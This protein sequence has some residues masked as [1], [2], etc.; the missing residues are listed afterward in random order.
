MQ[1]FIAE[2]N[3]V[4]NP[5]VQKKLGLKNAMSTPRIMKIIVNVGIGSRMKNTKDYSD[6]VDNVAAITGQRPIVTFAKKAISN[7]KLRENTPNG[8]MTILRRK[9]M[10]NF[11]NRLVNVALPR[12]RDF[13]GFSEK[14]FD[15]NGNYSI[16]IK[17]CTIFPEVD[18]DDLTHVHG[19]SIT[20]VTSADND[21]ASKI[22]LSA[23]SF[24]FKKAPVVEEK[25]EEMVEEAKAETPAAEDPDETKEETKEEVKEETSEEAPEEAKEEETKS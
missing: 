4:V 7:F 19:M 11:F 18:P 2:L 14:A 23:L 6:V 16:G 13:Q 25:A 22:L 17:D 10:L 21:E 24:P 20:I 1:D 8:V 15:N 3:T 5:K 9:K 12:I